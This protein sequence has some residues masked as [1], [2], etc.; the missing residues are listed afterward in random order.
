MVKGIFSTFVAFVGTATLADAF[1]C[2]DKTCS[3]ENVKHVTCFEG[4]FK[5]KCETKKGDPGD[6]DSYAIALLHVSSWCDAL[7]RDGDATATHPTGTRCKHIEV[8]RM[9]VH[10]LWTQ[11]DGGFPA[12][13]G[14]IENERIGSGDTVP[15]WN[16]PHKFSDA[17]HS[18]MLVN[19]IDP[20]DVAWNEWGSMCSIWQHEWLKHGSCAGLGA[21]TDTRSSYGARAYFSETMSVFHSLDESIAK[22]DALPGGKTVS[23][24]ALQ[25]MFPKKVELLCDNTLP[26][27]QDRLVELRA[28]FRKDEVTN[29]VG[30]PAD[31][32][33]PSAFGALRACG[34]V[35]E[36]GKEFTP[37]DSTFLS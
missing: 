12:C 21:P 36:I 37:K 4:K 15:H 2:P 10:G 30:A 34:D 27:G 32:G 16:D 24:S 17:L 33:P 13:C 23:A 9:T 5:S 25:E 1:W 7:E 29:K 18:D 11:Y 31:C 26:E 19:W 35:V 22:V 14:D 28:C 8:P 20:T 3:G 6:F